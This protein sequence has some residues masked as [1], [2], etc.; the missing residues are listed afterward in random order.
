M[1][2]ECLNLGVLCE[3]AGLNAEYRLDTMMCGAHPDRT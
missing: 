1:A 2:R 3:E